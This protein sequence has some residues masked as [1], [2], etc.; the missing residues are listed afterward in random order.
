DASESNSWA[1]YLRNAATLGCHLTIISINPQE[2][3]RR[4]DVDR[5]LV[6]MIRI[7]SKVINATY[8]GR[9]LAMVPQET[10]IRANALCAKVRIEDPVSLG[11][12]LEEGLVQVF[13]PGI[14]LV[15]LDLGAPDAS[16]RPII[17]TGY[18][19]RAKNMDAIEQ[20]CKLY[21]P[22]Y[23]GYTVGG[24]EFADEAEFYLL[25]GLKTSEFL[26]AMRTQA[27]S[28]AFKAYQKALKRW[29]SRDA[30]ETIQGK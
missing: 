1:T 11:D 13:F 10:G 5:G 16:R 9:E 8:D 26:W 18:G 21:A 28:P 24:D 22:S 4:G 6:D 7:N 27:D 20:I 3:C 23:F 15:P 12:M 25:I 29:A 30:K 19:N 14:R 2:P 17:Y